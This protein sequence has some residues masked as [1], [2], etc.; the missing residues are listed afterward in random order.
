M[1]ALELRD[2][3]VSDARE[4]VRVLGL[5]FGNV[6]TD[7]EV[8]AGVGKLYDPDWAIGFYDAGRLVSTAGA[9][10][11]ELTL[12]AGPGQ[13]FRSVAVPGVTAVGV[14]PTHRRRGLLSE[15]MA[16]QLGQFRDREVPLAVLVASESL[17]YGRYGYGLASSSQALAIATRRSSFAAARRPEGPAPGQLHLVGS[18]EA[19]TV[20]P[21]IHDHARRL[22]PGEVSRPGLYWEATL[23]D[24]EGSRGGA[25]ART[26]VVHEDSDGRADGYAS[27]RIHSKWGDGLPASSVEV[28]DLYST[29]PGTDAALWRFLL[30]IDL[31][32]ELTAWARPLD[33]ALRWR[34]AEPRRLRTTGVC[35]SLWALLV[36]VPAALEA[37][38]YGTE[39][40]L[41][42]E[43]TGAS[44][45]RYQ[46]ATAAEGGTCE[47]AKDSAPTDLVL[48]P[49]QLG[50]IYLGG[51]R[52]SVLAAAGLVE[53]RGPGLWRALTPRSPAPSSPF[54][55]PFFDLGLSSPTRLIGERF[56]GGFL[57]VPQIVSREH[58][59]VITNYARFDGT[60][61]PAAACEIQIAHIIRALLV[62]RS[63]AL[64][65]AG[66][67][68][69]LVC[70]HCCLIA[71]RL[72]RRFP[73]FV[74]A[75]RA[76]SVGPHRGLWSTS[77][78]GPR[79]TGFRVL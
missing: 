5:A 67:A 63:R 26:F 71:W 11:L 23:R 16:H 3:P 56:S 1:A 32:E 42:L 20:I 69:W 49:S 73:S 61:F 40:E 64:G 21:V 57:P 74:D 45:G 41:V 25:S 58:Q 70:S 68:S 17:I 75:R 48:G 6:G 10:N 43:V 52:P 38:G 59:N 31:V 13:P 27:Y 22:R 66:C 77:R 33:D 54:A 36:N 8:G 55:G 51:C 12:P 65:A 19:T 30:D 79:A 9:L 78:T 29:S 14:L 76:P 7:E 50:A 53:E 35:D 24:P 47:Q 60:G 18:A 72:L 37:R 39:T 62:P 28:E 4:F 2:V 46:L 15:M 34:L 44:G